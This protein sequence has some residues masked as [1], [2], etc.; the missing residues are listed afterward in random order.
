[1]TRKW[2]ANELQENE[3]V[4]S[5][6]INHYSKDKDLI[7][8]SYSREWTKNERKRKEDERKWSKLKRN[9]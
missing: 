3:R 8:L 2:K 6:L 4:Q 9:K 5:R 1:M 7:L